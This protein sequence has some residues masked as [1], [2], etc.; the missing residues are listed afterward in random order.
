MVKARELQPDSGRVLLRDGSAAT[1]TAAAPEDVQELEA[2]LQK[3]STESGLHRYLSKNIPEPGLAE[4]LCVAS[5][6]EQQCTLLVKR[7]LEGMGRIVAVG[8]YESRGSG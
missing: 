1:M 3:L 8:S 4:A 6:P 2:L 7:H 5:S